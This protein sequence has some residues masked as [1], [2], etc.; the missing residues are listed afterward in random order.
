MKE[1]SPQQFQRIPRPSSRPHPQAEEEKSEQP[2][3]RPGLRP[4]GITREDLSRSAADPTPD[5]IPKH[6]PTG[7]ARAIAPHL[8]EPQQAPE[9]PQP[10]PQF[11]PTGLARAIAPH[12]YEQQQAPE[13]PQPIPQPNPTGLARAIAP[14]LYSNPRDPENPATQDQQS[15]PRPIP[16]PQL[17][18]L[19]LAVTAQAQALLSEK[20][21]IQ[22]KDDSASNNT[23]EINLK[24]DPPPATESETASEEKNFPIQPQLKI[25]QPGDKYE[26][27]ANSKAAEIMKMEDP[28]ASEEIEKESSKNAIKEQPLAETITPLVQRKNNQKEGENS[29]SIEQ[30]LGQGGGQPLEKETRTFM[31]NR[32]GADFSSVRVHTDDSAVQMN[33]DIGAQAFTHEQDIYYGKGKSPGKNELTAHELTHTI[34]QSGSTIQ[35]KILS[36]STDKKEHKIQARTL[37]EIPGK[38]TPPTLPEGQSS[39]TSTTQTGENKVSRIGKPNQVRATFDQRAENGLIAQAFSTSEALRQEIEILIESLGLTQGQIDGLHRSTVT[40]LE[41]LL[42]ESD[43]QEYAN[44]RYHEIFLSLLQQRFEPDIENRQEQQNEYLREH[45]GK[46]P[47]EILEEIYALEESLNLS[48]SQHEELDRR[49]LDELIEIRLGNESNERLRLLHRAIFLSLLKQNY[50]P[51]IENRRR[52]RR[53]FANLE[54]AIPG[55]G[56]APAATTI[57]GSAEPMTYDEIFGQLLRDIGQN[58][59]LNIEPLINAAE[60]R[61]RELELVESESPNFDARTI[62]Y[63][64]LIRN[65]EWAR[66]VI[67]GTETQRP[68]LQEKFQALPTQAGQGQA[69]QASIEQRAAEIFKAVTGKEPGAEDRHLL[70]TFRNAILL[71]YFDYS[72]IPQGWVFIGQPSGAIAFWSMGNTQLE[73]RLKGFVQGND[74]VTTNK[75]GL[76]DAAALAR[77]AM[78]TGGEQGA[79][80]V[81][82]DGEEGGYSIL[83][84]EI[85]LP[86][87]GGPR[88]FSRHEVEGRTSQIVLT[89]DGRGL[90]IEAFVTTDGYLVE[91]DVSIVERGDRRTRIEGQ[92]VTSTTFPSEGGYEAVVKQD[93]PDLE[94]EGRINNEGRLAL[95]LGLVKAKALERLA[96]N[97]QRIQQAKAQYETSEGGG[98]NRAQGD[99]VSRLR[100][101]VETDE[102]LALKEIELELEINRQRNALRDEND[103]IRVDVAE[104][105]LEGLNRLE[106]QRQ[107]VKSVRKAIAQLYPASHLLEGDDVSEGVSDEK[108]AQRVS[109]KFETILGDIERVE[110]GVHNGDISLNDLDAVVQEALAELGEGK[111]QEV[112]QNYVRQQQNRKTAISLSTLAIGLGLTVATLFTGSILLALV[113]AA[114]GA[115]TAVYEFEQADDLNAVAGAQEAGGE[116][117]IEDPGGARFNYIMGWANLVLAGLDVGVAIREGGTLLRG[118]RAAEA[119]ANTA[120]DAGV[121]ARLSPDQ[122]QR[123]DRAVLLE[124]AGD[125]GAEALL[126]ELRRELGDD[127]EAAYDAWVEAPVADGLVPGCFVAGTPVLTPSGHQPI[128]MLQTGD[129][130]VSSEPETGQTTE[131]LISRCFRREVPVVFEI[132]VGTV[133]ITCSPEHPFWVVDEGWKKAGDLKVG[134]EIVTPSQESVKIEAIEHRKGSFTVYNIEVEGFHTY[135]VSSLSILVHNKS[136]NRPTGFSERAERAIQR[137]ENLMKDPIGEIN[138]QARH[139]HYDAARREAAGEI[140]SLREDGIP[141]DHINDLQEAYYGLENVRRAFEAERSNRRLTDRGRRILQRRYGQVQVEINKLRDFLVEI[142]HPPN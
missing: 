118:A 61:F 30:Q 141:H 94:K 86:A 67:G 75:V 25:G 44:Y 63:G 134:E 124:A 97:R 58:P 62:F 114:F 83:T 23:E 139:N 116:A 3:R 127:F 109:G 60:A 79:V 85:N 10:I 92:E 121:F 27:E 76:D 45:Q 91:P 82:L 24:A 131:G 49:A 89:G 52:D 125:E 13:N 20:S 38:K 42:T 55:E 135:R 101:V 17:T 41:K 140:V 65:F 21:N 119:I 133:T 68:Y 77:V 112:A 73:M 138:S 88:A 26:Q 142:G 111:A 37:S 78:A 54:A 59:D 115:G 34:Q 12:L 16:Q 123:L 137:Y 93:L 130:V 66:Q 56:R 122:I 108:I 48:N 31:E 15:D 28:A 43:S 120:Q 6:E 90:G 102:A 87:L 5:A 104:R 70:E 132:V 53:A 64:L 40:K 84:L 39:P 80:V 57:P 32:F 47:E 46:T 128:E 11:N 99:A 29:T 95:F 106:L 1:R 36:P 18:G 14:R 98:G 100:Q 129:I 7:L 22:T 96:Q 69:S 35:A 72:D 51:A 117:L 74:R 103:N 71:Q 110:I 8:Y 50:A 113:G 126:G 81:R 2:P 4:E 107:E 9:N 105:V 136:L 19:G 33:K